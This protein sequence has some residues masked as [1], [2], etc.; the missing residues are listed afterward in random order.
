M[1]EPDYYR[2]APSKVA[3]IVAIVSFGGSAIF[4]TAQLVKTRAR[5]MTAFVAGAYSYTIRLLSS[6]LPTSLLAYIGQYLFIILA[7]ALYAFSIHTIY[8]RIVVYTGKPHLSNIAPHKARR[9]FALSNALIILLQF[10]G[11]GMPIIQNDNMQSIGGKVLVVALFIQTTL[12][13]FFLYVSANFQ[14]RLWQ[15]GLGWFGGGSW[16]RLLHVLILVSVLVIVRCLYR[17][18]EEIEIVD[19]YLFAHEGYMYGFDAALMFCVQAALN[20]Y[21]PGKILKGSGLRE[22]EER[23]RTAADQTR[24]GTGTRSESDIKGPPGFIYKIR[25]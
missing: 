23:T 19:G 10:I 16:R 17:V 1:S 14:L 3:P 5:Y 12:F 8:R 9:L 24:T 7:P 15:C 4:H 6:F 2:N 22:Q 11:A 13:G 21:H 25:I 18:I 20:F